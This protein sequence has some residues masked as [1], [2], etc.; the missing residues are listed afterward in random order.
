MYFFIKKN[1][2]FILFFFGGGEEGASSMITSIF[3]N[4]IPQKSHKTLY[5]LVLFVFILVSKE[6]QKTG[7]GENNVTPLIQQCSAST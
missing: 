6:I 3:Q 4:A 5:F 2:S 7:F 1:Y